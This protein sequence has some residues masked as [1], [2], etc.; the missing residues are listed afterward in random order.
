MF[1]MPGVTVQDKGVSMTRNVTP[2]ASRKPALLEDAPIDALAPEHTGGDLIALPAELGASGAEDAALDDITG[3]E[4]DWAEATEA[5]E[6]AYRHTLL[7]EQGA[8]SAE[9]E[10]ADEEPACLKGEIEALLFMTN[11][12]LPI[13]E[14][15][16]LLESTLDATAEA[17]TELIGDYAFRS[18]TS[19]EIDDSPEGY[20]LQ[21]RR[22]YHHLLNA[23]IPMDISAAALRTLSVLAIRAPMLQ[24]DLIE[25]RGATAYEHVKELLRH[26]LIS[27]NR[28]GV[29]YRL[30]LTPTFHQHFKLTGS[31]QELDVLVESEL[32]SERQQREQA[33]TLSDRPDTSLEGLGLQL[34]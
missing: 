11:R 17:L 6:R 4:A 1:F 15:A 18:E 22:P 8:R 25:L 21:I 34:P 7:R 20:I 30:N 33:S 24:K 13:E 5:R 12:P 2:A 3:H 26:K 29:S 23:M 19:L 28:S 32:A 27:K 9:P 16:L 10:D 31:R 14:M